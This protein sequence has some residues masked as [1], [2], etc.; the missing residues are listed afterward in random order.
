MRRT[1]LLVLAA[2]VEAARQPTVV[3]AGATGTVGREL[4]RILRRQDVPTV[5]LGRDVL[6]AK[7]M[8]GIKTK[9]KE[10]DLSD[11]ESIK[12]ALPV[13]EPFRLFV[14]TPNGPDQFDLEKTL[15]DVCAQTDRCEHAVKVSTATPV[16][17]ARVG[18]FD[19]HTKAE[20]LL[21]DSLSHTILRPSLY[22]QTVFGEHGPLG[23]PSGAG[24]GQHVLADAPVAYISAVD[25][26]AVAA[27]A[28]VADDVSRNAKMLDL[29]GPAAATVSEVVSKA[30]G[31]VKPCTSPLPADFLRVLATQLSKVSH[32][33]EL[34]LGEEPTAASDYFMRELRRRALD[35]GLNG[36]IAY[37]GRAVYTA[38]YRSSL[39][40]DEV[41]RKSRGLGLRCREDYEELGV[42]KYAPSRP[43]D[44]FPDRWLGWDDY[45]GVRRPYDEG[46]RV[47]R[48]LGIASELRWYTY[49]L[50]R[51]AVLEDLRLPFRPPQAYGDEWR[52]WGDWLGTSV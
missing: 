13:D 1:T 21:A 29:T 34:S 6:R 28:L 23:L 7:R 27:R 10:V 18:P 30:G 50:D 52:G 41:R 51:P 45:L 39:P 46:R 26:A 9:C 12:A 22:A 2:V 35:C 5:A 19:A 4:V 24:D 14:A 20:A 48:T 31:S 16:L 40:F 32:D 33:T 8:L 3:V 37:N 17:E 25:V 36:E 47:A 49:A 42:P 15:F 38:N 11:A 43:E 44:M